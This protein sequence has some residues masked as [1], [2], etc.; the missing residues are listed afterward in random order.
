[1]DVAAKLTSKGQITV[2]KSVRDALGLRAGD[3]I[4][5]RVHGD[6]AVVAKTPDF[7]ELAGTIAVPAGRQGTSW[8]RVL[9]ETHRERAESRR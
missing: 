3:E 6:R 7:L 1:M 8:D 2:P 9:R 5:F 4:V